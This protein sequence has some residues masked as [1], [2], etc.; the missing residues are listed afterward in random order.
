MPTARAVRHH[1]ALVVVAVLLG[2]VAGWAYAGTM[3]TSYTST[4]RVLVD[5]AVGNPFVPTPTAVRQDELTSLETEA[6]V[7][8]SAEV[9]ASVAQQAPPWT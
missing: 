7:A 3:A 8:G 9:L 6:Q 5:P 4:A 1:L 2:A